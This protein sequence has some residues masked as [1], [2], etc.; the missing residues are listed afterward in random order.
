MAFSPFR[1]SV[2]SKQTTEKNEQIKTRDQKTGVRNQNP[3]ISDFGMR[4]AL[5]RLLGGML[6]NG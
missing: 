4:P 6:D 5:V 2:L 3:H 1:K